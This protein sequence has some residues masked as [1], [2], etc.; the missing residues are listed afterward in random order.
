MADER[1]TDTTFRPRRAE[2]GVGG[3]REVGGANLP[4]RAGDA[5]APARAPLKE[6]ERL[7]P[8]PLQRVLGFVILLSTVGLLSCQAFLN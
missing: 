8:K 3:A 2:G 7:L 4:R 6:P 5:P 1:P